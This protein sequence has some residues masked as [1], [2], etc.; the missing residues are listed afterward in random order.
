[1]PSALPP[2]TLEGWYALHQ[3]FALDWAR[4]ARPGAAT[5]APA[6]AAEAPRGSSSG[7]PRPEGEGWSA[8]FQLVGGGAELLFL[9]FR[10][11]PGGAGG[12]A[13]WRCGARALG[14]AAAAGATT[15]SR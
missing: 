6:L 2:A 13:S 11:T 14:D 4:P 5:G 8:A 12:G 7:W 1:M 10:P 3:V 15:S 9:H